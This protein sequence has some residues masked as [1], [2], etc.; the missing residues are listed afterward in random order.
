[1]DTDVRRRILDASV[2][3]LEAEGLAA[4]S[5][6][7]VARRS[8]VSH[9]APYHHFGDRE[10]ILAA[11][12]EEG[13]VELTAALA[14]CRQAS[15]LEA[16]LLEQGLAYVTFALRRP[17]HFRLMFRP[18]LVTLARFPEAERAA[19]EALDELKDMVTALRPRLGR[20]VSSEQLT[21]LHWA[22]VHGLAQLLLDGP[23]GVDL[24]DMDDRIAHAKAVLGAHAKVLLERRTV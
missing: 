10:A 12:V 9:Q 22:L 16:R 6:R 14:V 13:F 5:M 20:K 17:A 8:G 15:S 7:E 19:G 24:P 11:L 23:L 2:A 21:S 3:L 18:E 1:M 4:L